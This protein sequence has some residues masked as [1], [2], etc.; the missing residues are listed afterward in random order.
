M[1]Q[2]QRACLSRRSGL[3]VVVCGQSNHM[4]VKEDVSV[5]SYTTGCGNSHF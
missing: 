3:F 5:S 2:I 1:M 4:N